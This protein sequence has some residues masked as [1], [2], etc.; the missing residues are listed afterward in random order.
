MSEPDRGL[1]EGIRRALARV[2]EV[3]AAWLFGSRARGTAREDSDLD[4]AVAFAP[5]LD[6]RARH[7]STLR[8]LEALVTE[9]GALGERADVL[10]L[11][12]A[13]STVAFRAIRDGRL[14]LD[15]QDGT[16][17]RVVAR[18]ARRYDDEAPRRALFERAARAAAR[19]L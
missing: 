18:V 14:V 10:D 3:S 8:V 11:D 19:S 17:A 12:A 13:G 6:E 2:P 15:R 1:E 7:L 9:L 4:V 16:R 5:G